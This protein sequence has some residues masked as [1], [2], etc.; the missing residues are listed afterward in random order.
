MA[1]A[2]AEKLSV[3]RITKSDAVLFDGAGESLRR[4]KPTVDLRGF[5][6]GWVRSTPSL[7]YQQGL[8]LA[9][10]GGG[11]VKGFYRSRGKTT[12]YM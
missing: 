1:W 8:S 3:E 12:H 7:P 11:E 10:S 4:G 5:Y 9:F 2:A 6:G